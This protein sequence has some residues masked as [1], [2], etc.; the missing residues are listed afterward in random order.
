MGP[1]KIKQTSWKIFKI[2]GIFDNSSAFYFIRY[3]WRLNQNFSQFGALTSF[4]PLAPLLCFPHLPSSICS[5]HAQYSISDPLF[6]ASWRACCRP[7][8][9]FSFVVIFFFFC[10]VL[11]NCTKSFWKKSNNWERTKMACKKWLNSVAVC[12]I[13]NL[14]VQV[15]FNAESSRV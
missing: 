14:C 2:L 6:N 3:W 10:F 4:S 13:Y 12:Q 5:S 1:R 7:I 15:I 9:L 11:R 8:R